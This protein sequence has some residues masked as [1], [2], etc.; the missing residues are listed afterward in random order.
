MSAVANR[1]EVR[2]ALEADADGLIEGRVYEDAVIL[3][4][5]VLV[6]IEDV[7][8]DFNRFVV[9]PE[10]LFLEVPEGQTIQGG[11]GLR[12]VTFRRC[13]FHNVAFAAT[14]K[15]IAELRPKFEWPEEAQ[16]AQVAQASEAAAP[17]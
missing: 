17:R 11:I 13:E 14:A 1:Q 5:A 8:L 15:V 4:P 9:Q 2:L 6:P 12:H 3:G 16:A 10:G 7:T